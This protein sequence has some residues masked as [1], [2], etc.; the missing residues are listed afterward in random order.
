MALC[1]TDLDS[2]AGRQWSHLLALHI[3]HALNAM[4]CYTQNEIKSH[5]AFFTSVVCT[6]LG[7][8]P[9]ASNTLR[10]EYSPALTADHTPADHTPLEI[11]YC[12]KNA[13]KDSS[14]KPVI[15]RFVTDIIPQDAQQTR[16]ASLTTALQ[17]IGKL[18]ALEPLRL[19]GN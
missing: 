16:S 5:L 6:W 4:Q 1:N 7:P 17:V 9:T 18:R 11:S 3:E 13:D 19:T 2:H 12:W 15:A 14:T 10:A 8:P